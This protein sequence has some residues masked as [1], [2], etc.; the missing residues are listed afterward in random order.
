[1]EILSGAQEKLDEWAS[2]PFGERLFEGYEHW[3][4]ATE[5][6]AQ[7]D[8]IM[9][10]AEAQAAQAQAIT[11]AVTIGAAVVGVVAVGALLVKLIK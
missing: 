10:Q 1:M 2:S 3:T 9:A 6:E 8:A 11:S 7:R 5:A 4:R